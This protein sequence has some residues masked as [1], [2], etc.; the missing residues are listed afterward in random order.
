MVLCVAASARRQRLRRQGVRVWHRPDH[1]LCLHRR[2]NS[3]MET[4]KQCALSAVVEER[5]EQY[6]MQRIGSTK[7]LSSRQIKQVS[8]LLTTEGYKA[9]LK[10]Q[11][12]A[13]AI[14]RTT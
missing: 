13:K 7:P 11:F 4:R 1:A 2:K 12:H 14:R 8:T 3:L 10:A 9:H 6:K 5:A